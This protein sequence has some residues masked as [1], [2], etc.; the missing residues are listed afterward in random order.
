MT[1]DQS[2]VEETRFGTW[3]IG[4]DTWRLRVLRR[5]LDDLERLLG[6]L[7][8]ERF[9]AIVDVGF[10]WGFSLV[11]LDH[12][13][14]PERLVG[15]DPDEQAIERAAPC[16]KAC[17]A[18]PELLTRN[19]ADTQLESDAFDMVFCHQTFH[20]IVDQESA[21]REF[22]RVLRPGG[23]LL[24]A[25]STK[26]YIHSWLI[27]WL[28]R[29]PMHVQKTAGEYIALIRD[30]GFDVPPER[31]SLPYLWWSRSDLGALE[32]LGVPVP[33]RREETLVNLVAV[34][35]GPTR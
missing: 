15:V 28:F 25:E 24:F 30:T 2:Y 3:F 4:T 13:F 23:V 7:R 20:P 16:A 21:M 17:D 34:K 8:A 10:G 5:A 11:E 32:W 31:I 26:A 33:A 6:P 29:H 22:Y 14:R 18:A 1:V 9:P 35:P 12:R 27:R 19:A